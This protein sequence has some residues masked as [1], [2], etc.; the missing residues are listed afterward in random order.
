MKRGTPSVLGALP[1]LAAVTAAL[2]VSA[3]ASI[4]FPRA[5]HAAPATAE[6]SPSSPPTTTPEPT[7]A[8]EPTTTPEPEPAFVMDSLEP[9]FIG[10][11]SARVP[12]APA[13][14]TKVRWVFSVTGLPEGE[15]FHYW[16]YMTDAGQTEGVATTF[17]TVETP[18]HDTIKDGYIDYLVDDI[19]NPPDVTFRLESVTF[20]TSAPAAGAGSES[21]A[22]DSGADSPGA[23]Q[24]GARSGVSTAAQIDTATGEE[25]LPFTGANDALL[26]WAAVF[27]MLG[28]SM[29]ASAARL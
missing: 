9:E 6:T 2:L 4:V 12:G 14:P 10:Y 13:K 25:F 11:A 8:P 7:V 23:S 24:S 1:V 19:N 22:G 26:V 21:N 29:R 17:V 28:G 5:A 18:G 27:A 3:P 20:E 16:I 15:E